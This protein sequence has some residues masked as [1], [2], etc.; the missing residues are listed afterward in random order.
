MREGVQLDVDGFVAEELTR[1]KQGRHTFRL[2]GNYIM[3]AEGTE[4]RIDRV[5]MLTRTNGWEPVNEVLGP[6]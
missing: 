2:M 1:W 5:E 3:H 6:Q 4:T